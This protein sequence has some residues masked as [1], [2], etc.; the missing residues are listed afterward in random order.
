M[1]SMN[2]IYNIT[3]KR[4]NEFLHWAHI[5]FSIYFTLS[6]TEMSPVETQSKYR[7]V[8]QESSKCTY[9]YRQILVD[10]IPKYS[11]VQNARKG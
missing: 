7:P 9:E 1:N 3:N 6:Q 8:H 2:G 5:Y 10:K 11:T 4:N